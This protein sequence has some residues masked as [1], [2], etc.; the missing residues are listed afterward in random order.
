[1]NASSLRTADLPRPQRM[2][3][4]AGTALLAAALAL[5]SLGLGSAPAWAAERVAGSGNSATEIRDGLGEFEAIALRGSID[6]VVR[7]GSPSAVSVTADDNL[8]A[9][10]ETTV[11]G[12]SGGPRLVVRW[13]PGTSIHTRSKVTV[14]V[15]TPRLGALASA[16][17]GDIRVEALDTPRLELS[18]SGSGD[19]ALARLK[20][21]ELRISISGS[22]DVKAE[23]QA[24]R[25][26][27]SIA[28]SGDVDATRLPTDEAS[29]SI[30][31]SGDVAVTAV[32]KLSVSIAGSGDVI[33]TGEP[34]V[35]RSVAGSG[36]V[37]RR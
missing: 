14:Q 34:E 25:L 31:G 22:G 4:A 24:S 13:K 5:A 30:A 20:T 17:S 6:L 28:G 11:Q 23:G 8:L 26:R 27:I 9:L 12:G 18:L 16:G 2:T 19:A 21:E 33:Y 35:T 29:V 1:M 3:Q 32:K 15:T 10:V 7:Q 36:T 37:K